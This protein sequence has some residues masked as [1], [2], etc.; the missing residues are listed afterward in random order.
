MKR[1]K[2]IA[3]WTLIVLGVL[4]VLFFTAGLI[5]DVKYS[6][7]REITINDT[8]ENVWKLITDTR[9]F[10][11]SRHEVKKMEM[12]EKTPEGFPSWREYTPWWGTMTYV[13]TG[14][15]PGETLSIS[16]VR[17]DFG[18]S[19]DWVFKIVPAGKQTKV[20]L[21]ETSS[22]EGIMMRSILTILGRDAN[23]G[24]LLRT[25]EKELKN[26]KV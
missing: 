9:R 18:L 25:I 1:F 24:L 4:V 2:K 3:K 23:M 14:Q 21:T 10:S 13:S 17:S 16:M 22:A 7:S 5:G 15:V 11:E 19:G 20:I 6:G 8:P 12:L 26:E